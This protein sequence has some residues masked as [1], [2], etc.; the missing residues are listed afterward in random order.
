MSVSD[1]FALERE[2]WNRENLRVVFTRPE[3]IAP[4]SYKYE[5]KARGTYEVSQRV[6]A[7]VGK[8][9]PFLVI[10]QFGTPHSYRGLDCG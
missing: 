1:A 10:D 2:I 9:T 3:A 8:G 6:I 5:A 7:T 4:A